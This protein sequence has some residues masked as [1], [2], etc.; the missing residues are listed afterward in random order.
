MTAQW[1]LLII[2]AT[3]AALFIVWGA[4][5]AFNGIVYEMRLLQE[6]FTHDDEPEEEKA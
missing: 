4:L 1:M 6:Y 2:L 3:V 5:K